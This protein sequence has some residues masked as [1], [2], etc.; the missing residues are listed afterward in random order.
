MKP[1][2]WPVRAHVVGEGCVTQSCIRGLSNRQNREIVQLIF[3]KN[4]FQENNRPLNSFFLTDS[5]TFQLK[6]QTQ[7]GAVQSNNLLG[8]QVTV[9]VSWQ[10]HPLM[11]LAPLMCLTF[12]PLY[13]WRSHSS[14][15]SLLGCIDTFTHLKKWTITVRV[16]NLR[17]C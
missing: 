7:D 6:D 14:F 10:L 17:I 12:L 8:L 3:R 1:S 16:T 13:S 11:L 2:Y 15:F 4:C 5:C 9:I